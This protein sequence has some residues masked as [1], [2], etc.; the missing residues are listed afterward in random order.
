[1]LFYKNYVL[2]HGFRVA[3]LCNNLCNELQLGKIRKINI[4]IGAV[5][6]DIGKYKIDRKILNKPCELTDEEFEIM[7][8]H[9]DIKY[10]P[11]ENKVVRNII[12]YHHENEDGT[13]YK[14]MTDIPIESKIV[15]ICDVFDALTHKR[16]YHDKVT[17]LEAI[18]ILLEESKN[19]DINILH[20]FIKIV[21]N[22]KSYNCI[23]NSYRKTLKDAQ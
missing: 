19:Y 7:K 14:K 9:V 3:I 21:L 23:Y 6:H 1:M 2:S 10:F 4:F 8:G 22:D 18:K 13:G 15:H 5:L 11:F 12:F 16:V 17:E 20:K